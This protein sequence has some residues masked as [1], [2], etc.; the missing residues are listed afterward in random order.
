MELRLLKPAGHPFEGLSARLQ[1]TPG[2]GITQQV[3]QGALR[4]GEHPLCENSLRDAVA[5][6]FGDD[7]LGQV[8]G[9]DLLPAT[10]A[11]GASTAGT[12]RGAGQHAIAWKRGQGGAAGV[13]LPD[14]GGLLV[15]QVLLVVLAVEVWVVTASWVLVGLHL[16]ELV[17]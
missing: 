12:T 17:A 10:A 13:E 1:L 16:V 7:P 14:F 3:G 15:G 4:A 8:F 2:L 9:V 6:Q 11:P 5:L